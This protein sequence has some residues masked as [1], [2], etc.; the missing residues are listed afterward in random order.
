MAG[1]RTPEELELMF[2]DAFVLHDQEVLAQLFEPGALL[3]P[4]GWRGPAHGREQ[5]EHLV[6]DLWHHHVVY[7]ADP[8]TVLQLGDTALIIGDVAINVVRRGP[9]GTWRY[10]IVHLCR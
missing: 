10:A 7:V 5:I 4:A 6:L 8:Q 2:E 9:D 1:A 3:H